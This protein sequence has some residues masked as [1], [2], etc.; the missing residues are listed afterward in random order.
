MN[1][2]GQ[3][4]VILE[5]KQ[6]K[7]QYT[8]DRG[9]FN[10]EVMILQ[11][12]QGHVNFPKLLS[13]DIQTMTIVLK[14]YTA[15]PKI[16]KYIKKIGTAVDYLH[17]MGIIHSDLKPANILYD[18]TTDEPIIIDFGVSNFDI[19]EPHWT[20]TDGYISPYSKRRMTFEAYSYDVWSL[21]I[22]FKLGVPHRPGLRPTA[23]DL[24]KCKT[25][26]QC[27][28]DRY[29]TRGNWQT[30][31]STNYTSNESEPCISLDIQAKTNLFRYHKELGKTAEASRYVL[32]ATGFAHCD[33]DTMK[34]LTRTM[35]NILSNEHVTEIQPPKYN[36]LRWMMKHGLKNA[37]QVLYA[38][39]IDEKLDVTE[40]VRYPTEFHRSFILPVHVCF[41]DCNLSRNTI[42]CQL[43]PVANK[44]LEHHVQ[45]Q[46]NITYLKNKLI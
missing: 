10:R 41:Y 46:D 12:L 45:V 13:F 43:L 19:H 2:S 30:S 28:Y 39:F 35:L 8:N 23:G 11:M 36:L 1:T 27:M 7:K 20:G 17:F 14:R 25:K 6:V 26:K 3:S 44:L 18:K 37:D 32:L 16:D 15:L 22:M 29:F 4:T 34:R 9:A 21:G 40:V 5:S 31:H 38:L 24:V 42:A 33:Y